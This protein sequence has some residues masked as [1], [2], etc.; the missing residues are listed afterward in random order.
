[1]L[2]FFFLIGDKPRHPPTPPPVGAKPPPKPGAPPPFPTQRPPVISQISQGQ[3]SM[4][5]VRSRRLPCTAEAERGREGQRGR[6]AR[7]AP[8]TRRPPDLHRR[9]VGRLRF[10]CPLLDALPN[11]LPTPLLP[12]IRRP[13]DPPLRRRRTPYAPPR[14]RYV[15]AMTWRGTG[16]LFSIS[17][18]F[19]SFPP[20]LLL[21]LSLSL[22]LSI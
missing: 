13:P 17:F 14:R 5:Y 20:S 1:V 21:S 19:P 2:F 8:A 12:P 16:A 6:G 7:T 3:V 4:G 22:S 18:S 15:T 11:P 9:L 10:P